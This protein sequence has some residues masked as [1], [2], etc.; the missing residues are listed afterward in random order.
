[1]FQPVLKLQVP[2]IR[3]NS[4]SV[5]T[6]M[7]LTKMYIADI[8]RHNVKQLLIDRIY[9]KDSRVVESIIILERAK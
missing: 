4:G 3:F 8:I 6:C 1:M 5:T 7:P 2:R 9:I